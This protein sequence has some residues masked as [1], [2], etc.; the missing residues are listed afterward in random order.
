MIFRPVARFAVMITALS[1]ALAHPAA[2]AGRDS[3]TRIDAVFAQFDKPDS[4]GCALAV[5]DHGTIAYQRGYGRASLELGV[6]ITPQT[7]FD[8]ASVSG[9]TPIAACGAFTTTARGPVIGR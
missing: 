1:A 8:V 3:N 9:L 7:V 5:I 6:P 2:Q 4:P